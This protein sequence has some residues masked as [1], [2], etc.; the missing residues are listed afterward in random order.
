MVRQFSSDWVLDLDTGDV[1]YT[2]NLFDWG[3]T[4]ISR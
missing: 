1:V 3:D 4:Y 2:G